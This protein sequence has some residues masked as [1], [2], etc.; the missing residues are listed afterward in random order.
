VR[1][2]PNEGLRVRTERWREQQIDPA[3]AQPRLDG[4]A[5]S[6]FYCELIGRRCNARRVN[7]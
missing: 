6:A 5:Q 7:Q 3:L 1:G 4:R 2:K